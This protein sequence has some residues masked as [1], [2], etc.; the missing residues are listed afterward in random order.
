MSH[1]NKPTPG[2]WV[3]DRTTV[4]RKLAVRA[5]DS[6]F[7][8]CTFEAFVKN[9][10][11]NARLCAAAP[12]LFEALK[13]YMSQFGQAL[14]AHGIAWSDAQIQADRAARSAIQ[15]AGSEQ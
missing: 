1:D 3:T 2:P 11:A 13:G 10:E 4:E 5:A 9:H 15:R 7:A 8:I 14:D 6:Q 12:D